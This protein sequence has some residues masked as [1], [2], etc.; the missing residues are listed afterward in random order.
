[1]VICK[2][3]KSVLSSLMRV[4]ILLVMV[5]A[6]CQPAYAK[7]MVDV[8]PPLIPLKEFFCNP[9]AAEYQISPDGNKFAF[10]KPYNNRLNIFVQSSA[11]TKAKQITATTA[12]DIRT[13]F[14]KN[15]QLIIYSQ[16]CDGDEN[17]HIYAADIQTGKSQ[18]LTPFPGVR[19]RIVDSLPDNEQEILISTNQRNPKKFDVY[20]LVLATGEMKLEVENPG[21]FMG[22][23]TDNQGVVRIAYGKNVI[24]GNYLMYYRTTADQPFNVILST[25]YRE[26]VSA[27]RFDAANQKI[28]ML[29]NKGRDKLALVMFNPDQEKEE[30]V[31]FE[32]PDVDIAGASISQKNK[33]LLFAYYVTDKFHNYFFDKEAQAIYDRLTAHFGNNDFK[34]A[35]TNKNRDKYIIFE[36]SASNPGAYYFYDSTADKLTK[37]ADVAPWLK[38]EQLATMQPIQYTTRDGYTVHGYLTL[39]KGR[40]TKNL[41]V[42]INPHG[43]PMGRDAW[44]YRADVQFLANRGYAVL[45][46]NFRGS[47]GYGK[48]F[49]NAGNKEWGKKMQ[50]DITDGAKWLID[51]HIADPKRIGIYGASYGGYA[52]LAGLAFTPELYACGVDM[53]GPSNL[54]TFIASVPPYWK[55]M[56][57]EFYERIGHPD[58]DAELLK[59]AS[60]V[61]HA[62]KIRAPLFVAQGA[63]DPRVKIKESEQIVGALRDRGIPVEYMVKD[64]EG[65]GFYKEENRLEFYQAM[66]K[67]LNTYL[68]PAP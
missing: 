29:S 32:N 23:K 68:K 1:M 21:N 40:G 25:D 8:K 50:D 15:E 38:E 2:I 65:H 34:I 5:T 10:L 62:D 26:Y 46:M 12:S 36:Y 60:P 53:C 19:V 18:D 63:N 37:L 16:D 52:V 20:R 7:E 4:G 61:F 49:V 17:Y 67:F 58:K 42:I 66:E 44:G 59:A 24:N 11:D 28:F 51:Q 45:Q 64:D 3:F 48:A 35:S 56:I 13:Y 9:E 55:P 47:I 43:G 22:Y 54:F 41:P 33:N 6:V 30:A 14:W 57:D 31:L 27:L 39:P